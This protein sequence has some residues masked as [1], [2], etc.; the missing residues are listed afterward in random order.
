MEVL[1][2]EGATDFGTAETEGESNEETSLDVC[3]GGCTAVLIRER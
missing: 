2:D 1:S 3:H